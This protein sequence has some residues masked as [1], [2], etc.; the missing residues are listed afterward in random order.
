MSPRPHPLGVQS[1]PEWDGVWDRYI[2]NDEA[3]NPPEAANDTDEELA[4]REAFPGRAIAWGGFAAL[5][6][7]AVLIGALV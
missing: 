3:M 2:A 4:E 6:I 5:A 7:A 1:H